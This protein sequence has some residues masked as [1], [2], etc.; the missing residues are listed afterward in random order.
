MTDL[1]YDEYIDSPQWRRRR[2]EYF[3]RHNRLCR[4]C[5]KGKKI[6]LHHLTYERMG[7]ELDRDLMALCERC[8]SAIHGYAAKNPKMSLEQATFAA[9]RALVAPKRSRRTRSTIL[10]GKVMSGMDPEYTRRRDARDRYK[11]ELANR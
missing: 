10:N 6:H 4:V 5:G 8:H 3:A 2:V 1:L 9:V 7:A 11:A